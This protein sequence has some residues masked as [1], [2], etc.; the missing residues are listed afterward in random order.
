MDDTTVSFAV[1]DMLITVTTGDSGVKEF[2]ARGP[3]RGKKDTAK[4]SA[5]ATAPKSLQPHFR[6]YF[7]SQKTVEESRGGVPVSLSPHQ[8]CVS[9]PQNRGRHADAPTK[10]AGTLFLQSKWWSQTTFPSDLFR[11]AKAT[12]QRMLMHNKVMFVTGGS[13][14]PWAYVGSANLSESAWYVVR[15]LG[16]TRE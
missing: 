14:C 8:Y 9:R 13:T 7:P 16:M 11:E 4:P 5:T 15:S 12:R 3:A 6:I 2:D 1:P 10:G